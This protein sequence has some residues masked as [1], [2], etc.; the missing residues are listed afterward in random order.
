MNRIALLPEQVA[1]QIAAG[2]VIERPASALKEIIENSLD[3]G[4]TQIDVQVRGGGRSLLVV[5]D[6]G[7]GM[8]KDDA[9]LCLERHATSKLRTSEDLSRIGSYGFRGEA[10][11]SIASV[12]KFRL[13]S[14]EPEALA[15]TEIVVNGGKLVEVRETGMAPGTQVEIRSLFFN[16]P[17]RRKFLRTEPT[18]TAHIK[19]QMILAGLARPDVGFSVAY[20]DAP[21]ERWPA[22]QALGDRIAAIYSD[23]FLRQMIPIEAEEDGLRLTGFIGQ[24]G[25]SRAGRQE[26]HIFV[27]GRPVTSRTLQ[28]G[29]QEGY[30]NALMRGR[31]PVCVLFL[32]MD[33]AGVDVNIH[34]AKRE[35]RFH[36]DMRVRQFIVK[37]VL[38]VLQGFHSTPVHA[39][40]PEPWK[41]AYHPAPQPPSF[42]TPL[43][44]LLQLRPES[45]GALESQPDLGLPVVSHAPAAAPRAHAPENALGLR[46]LGAVANLYLIAEGSEGL[47]LIDQHAAHERVLFEQ[48]LRRVAQQEI[49]SQ[50]LLLP[51][52]LELPPRDAD[53]LLAQMETLNQVGVG[54]SL[55]GATTFL[56]DALPPMVKTRDVTEFMRNLVTDLQESGGETRKTRRV[57][58]EVIAKTVCRHAVKANDALRPDEWDR[59]VADLLAC[60]LPYTCPHGRPTMIQISL[61][62]LEKKFGRTQG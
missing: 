5:T 57:S 54:I 3:A 47:V 41:P 29:L 14:R 8:S 36:D 33:P 19:H 42:I 28:F 27:N 24:P 1:N 53:F 46:V 17:A 61:A 56:I 18:E 25:V 9:L 11:P 12:S 6:N 35:V 44:S 60:D 16:M 39:T 37:S 22:A 7:W 13:R 52:T 31:Y 51:A 32:T 40:V 34:P 45:V 43:P 55:F 2:E 15:G 20:D 30:H 10:V 38:E 21:A 58:E 4:A 48:M 49:L 26:E 23:E 62:E 50:K 59:L